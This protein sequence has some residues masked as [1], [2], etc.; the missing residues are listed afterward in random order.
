MKSLLLAFALLFLPAFATAQT[1]VLRPDLD[2]LN[3]G[4]RSLA[5]DG[6]DPVAYFPEAGGKPAKGKKNITWNHRGVVYRFANER[7]RM[8]FQGHPVRYEP[9]YGGWCAWAMAKD[10]RVDIDPDSFL[11]QDGELLLFYDGF[12]ADTRKKWRKGN[13][14]ALK[15]KADSTWNKHYGHAARD[16]S[17]IHLTG[18][19]AADGFDVITLHDPKQDA[20]KGAPQHKHEYR[21][22]TYRFATQANRKRFMADPSRFEP[23]L[24][25]WDPN[26]LAGGLHTAGLPA[27]SMVHGKHVYLFASAESKASFDGKDREARLK[28]AIKTFMAPR[29]KSPAKEATGKGK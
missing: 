23:A 10:D 4:K 7:N 8:L 16:L 13:V 9:A 6:Y 15:V 17:R 26:A 25:G 24:G 29:K 27:Y 19:V 14:S 2:K 12:L 5:I 20:A 1:P 18:G 3:L 11:I 22:A 28:L 21:G